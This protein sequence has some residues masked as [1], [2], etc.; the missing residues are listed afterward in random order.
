MLRVVLGQDRFVG[1]VRLG[2]CRTLV[3]VELDDEH[4]GAVCGD[5]ERD[6]RRRRHE[7]FD[8]RL[9]RGC[10]RFRRRRGRGPLAREEGHGR[11]GGAEEHDGHGNGE[12]TAAPAANI[13]GC[14]TRKCSHGISCGRPGDQEQCDHGGIRGQTQ[15][16]DR[17]QHNERRVTEVQHDGETDRGQ[18][19]EI[20][21]RVVARSGRPRL[22]AGDQQQG[23]D[24]PDHAEDR[25]RNSGER[26]EPAHIHLRAGD[27]GVDVARARVGWIAQ[28]VV[29]HVGG[30]RRGGK[31]QQAKHEQPRARA[32]G[33]LTRKG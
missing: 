20:A 24:E 31:A 25:D 9:L 6:A 5:D 14:T 12:R 32:A 27:R 26:A 3:V 13:L 10:E 15:D 8:F 18:H 17:F 1:Q 11:R 30:R 28:H 16:T 7:P 4:L 23:R 21:G 2:A 33:H 22:R 29:M 19:K